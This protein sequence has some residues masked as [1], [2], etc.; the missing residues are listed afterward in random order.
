MADK[1]KKNNIDKI[2]ENLQ[3]FFI[4]WGFVLVLNQIFIFGAC[5][6]PYCLIAALPHTGVIAFFLTLYSLKSEDVSES[7][8]EYEKKHREEVIRNIV[9][10]T[11]QKEK[12]YLQNKQNLKINILKWEMIMKNILDNNLKEKAI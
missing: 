2:K 1:N 5:F 3:Q 11:K 7:T 12:V 10:S 9:N 8:K 4:I 6:A